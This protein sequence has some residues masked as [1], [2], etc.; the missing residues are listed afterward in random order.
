MNSQSSIQTLFKSYRAQRNA[1]ESTSDPNSASYQERLQAALST[2]QECH[3]IIERSAL[4]S[5]N[6][7]EDDISSGDLQ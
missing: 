6:E 5:T 7:T 2:L 3:E 1:L 4:F